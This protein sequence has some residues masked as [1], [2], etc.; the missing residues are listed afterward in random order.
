MG[1]QIMC[2]IQINQPTRCNN[3]SSLLLD[4][5]LQLNMFQVSPRP[6][7]GA[8]QLQLPPLVLPSERGD[9]SADGR[10]RAEHDQQHYYHHAPTVKPESATVVVELLMM[11]VRMPETCWAV[12]KSQVINWR[13]CC[14]WLVDLFQLHIVE[15]FLRSEHVR[16]YSRNSQNFMEPEGSLR[17][18]QKPATPPD[19]QPD[20]SSPKFQVGFSTT[21][22]AKR[23]SQSPRTSEEF[24]TYYVLNGEE[25]LAPR[26]TPRL[27][28]HPL[29]A[30]GNCLINIFVATLH[31]EAVPPP[32]TWGRDHAAMARTH[33]SQTLLQ[34]N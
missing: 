19:P 21:W 9:S 30:V 27:E 12:N 24:H 22:V 4:V 10:G 15:S 31:T 20:Q 29:S 16:S 3:L 34:I 8:Q 26:S 13:D 28:Y 23:I 25:L 6:S 32:A 17:L 2:I 7:S 5:Y 11:G 1:T 14:I 33:L 18:S